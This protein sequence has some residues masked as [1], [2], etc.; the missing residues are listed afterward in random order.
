MQNVSKAVMIVD[1]DPII[2]E[3]CC[4]QLEEMGH[5]VLV[6]RSGAH[7][8]RQ[9]REQKIDAV[10]LDIIMPDK[11][12]IETLLE[13]KKNWP[14]LRVYAMSGGGRASLRVFLDAA[15]KLGAD[16]ILKKPF[17][18]LDMLKLLVPA[19]AGVWEVP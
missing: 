12:G 15:M 7:A 3:T 16:G 8:L 5:T 10:F 13:I 9:L 17:F 4:Y 2:L 14:S 19:E 11:D 6:A 1:D 18:P